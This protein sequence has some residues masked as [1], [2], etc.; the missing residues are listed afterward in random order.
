MIIFFQYCLFRSGSALVRI[1][2]NPY[3]CVPILMCIGRDTYYIL[4]RIHAQLLIL[5]VIVIVRV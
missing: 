4:I 2:S 1:S 5:H 3:E